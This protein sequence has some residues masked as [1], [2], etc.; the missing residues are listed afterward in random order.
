MTDEGG[1]RVLPPADEAGIPRLLDRETFEPVSLASGGHEAS[2]GDLR[3]GYLVDADLDWSRPAATVRSLTL[4]RPTLYAFADSVEPMFEL[5]RETWRDARSAGEAMDS[6]IARNTDGETVGAVYVFAEGGDRG[7][8][9]EF[10]DGSRPLEPL[11]DRANED[12]AAP[13]EAFVLRPTEGTFTAVA[14][15]LRKGGQFPDTL[16]DT[17]DLPRPDEPLAGDDTAGGK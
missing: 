7:R 2:V 15:A 9:E 14:V 17:Y 5:A 11:V 8:L 12:G 10:R 16:R 3:P 6:R 13:R 4:R 1:Y